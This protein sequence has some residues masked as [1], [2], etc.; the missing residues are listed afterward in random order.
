MYVHSRN[1]HITVPK[2]TLS[3]LIFALYILSIGTCDRDPCPSG[4]VCT[5]VQGSPPICA[6]PPGSTIPGCTTVDPCDV[7]P[8]HNDGNCTALNITEY[9]CT[10][11]PGYTGVECMTGRKTGSYDH[12]HI[13]IRAHVAM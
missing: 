10:C 8:C 13:T 5:P 1:T 3:G 12:M 9:M 2:F 6:C 4:A 7:D 11:P